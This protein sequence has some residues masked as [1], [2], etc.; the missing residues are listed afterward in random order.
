MTTVNLSR[1]CSKLSKKRA[2]SDVPQPGRA[3]ARKLQS[4]C[5]VIVD[6]HCHAGIGDGLTGPW[7]TE[8][9]L[10]RY[11][12]RATRA[13]I[14]RTVV[15]STFD[16]DYAVANR[17]VARIVHGSRGRLY[18]F[19]FVHAVRDAG[20]VSALVRDAVERYGF[21]GNKVHRHDARISREICEAARQFQVP[22]LYDPVGEVGPV[23]LMAGEYPDVR[24]IIPH[25]GSFDDDW[26]A[27]VAMIGLLMRHD[28]VYVDTSAVRRFDLLAEAAHR[29]PR[30]VLFGS[31]G[32]WLHPGVEL[33]KVRLLGLRQA[34]EQLVLG[35]NVLRIVDP[36]ALPRVSRARR[37][38]TPGTTAIG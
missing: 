37:R 18:G 5:Q 13:G 22:V 23:E 27:Q 6:C 8:A 10:T 25:L 31:D 28:N 33:A 30:R 20:R 35:G 24:F 3:L 15:F 4:Q 14:G 26:S 38:R 32:P 21:R 12:E 36:S 1:V 2:R 9:H 7:D 16:S 17:R 11:L 34:D 19:A 29:R